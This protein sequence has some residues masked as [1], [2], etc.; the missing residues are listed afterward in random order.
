MADMVAKS[1]FVADEMV[2]NWRVVVD[3][4]TECSRSDLLAAAKAGAVE[5]CLETAES[6]RLKARRGRRMDASI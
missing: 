5:L 6:R 2:G 4:A 1:L 3:A